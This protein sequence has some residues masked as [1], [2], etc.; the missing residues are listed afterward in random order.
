LRASTLPLDSLRGA[1][2]TASLALVATEHARRGSVFVICSHG[3]SCQAFRRAC[4]ER[5]APAALVVGTLSGHLARL[6]R[7]DSASSGVSPNFIVGGQAAARAIVTQAA[8]GML[9]LRWPE[10]RDGSVDIEVPY[11][12]RV[13]TL[14]DE[15]AALI[16]WLR[17]NRVTPA[18]FRAS[19]DSGVREFYGA[20]VEDARV[21]LA[22]PETVR[23]ASRRAREALRVDEDVLRMQRR[24]ERDLGILLARM[25]EEYLAI[26]RH[27]AVKSEADVI[28]S[29]IA[30]LTSDKAAARRAFRGV[31]AM[32]VDDAED[33]EPALPEML[34]VARAAGVDEVIVAGRD[35]SAID[36]LGGRRSCSATDA[37]Q[38]PF[39][40]AL[41]PH[42]SAWRFHDESAEADFIARATLDL[43]ESGVRSDDIVV[44]ARDDDAAAAYATLL[45]ERG[46]PVLPP[47]ARFAAAADIADLFALARVCDDPFDQAH[48]LRVLAS[49]LAG[50]S[51][52]SLF[53]LCSD[54]APQRQLTLEIGVGPPA[55]GGAG[56]ANVTRLA[57]NV[58][59]GAADIALPEET[60]RTMSA[61]RE[62]MA[63]WRNACARLAPPDALR[64]LIAA[65]GF[66]ARWRLAQ[67]HM[68]ARLAADASRL[69]RAFEAAWASGACRNLSQTVALIEDEVVAP[70]LAARVEGAVACEGVIAVKGTRFAHVFVAGVSRERFPRVYIPR[71]LAFSRTFGIVVRENVA[72]GPKQ[73][74]KFAW[75]YAKFGAKRRYLEGE[76]RV[77]NYAASRAT[78]SVTITGFGTAPFWAADEDL[79][80]RFIRDAG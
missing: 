45:A 1:G 50:L 28:D 17:R 76:R 40:R 22:D 67:P 79:L 73:A 21:R 32:V 41:S 14:L 68:A 75:Y 43:I 16:E 77:L 54:P 24:A 30:W 15:S 27:A 44:L 8:R 11:A 55:R 39:A 48:L 70:E 12:R 62:Q 57:D 19:C 2:M 3:S 9:D 7:A 4:G 33:A 58:L 47:S 78:V 71:S 37:V 25:Y 5:D 74:A 72:L 59:S 46:V 42:P 53:A 69:V 80:A 38:P 18:A 64:Y 65:A 60:R 13:D 20:D 29:G 61:L 34:A 63:T 56:S 52:A 49:P 6:M 23:R 66:D 35:S 10:L 36:H 26:E 31:A 51:D